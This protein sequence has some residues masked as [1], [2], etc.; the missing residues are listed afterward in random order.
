M[1]LASWFVFVFAGAKAGD[2]GVNVVY[3][4]QPYARR[5]TNDKNWVKTIP[6][7]LSQTIVLI[8]LAIFSIG[9]H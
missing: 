3:D 1:H 6:E 2:L 4:E 7:K 5:T 9:A 8:L